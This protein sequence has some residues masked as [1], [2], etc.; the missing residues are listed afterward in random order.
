MQLL[1]ILK[2]ELLYGGLSKEEFQQVKEPVREQNQKLLV[3]WSIATGLFWAASLFLY[4]EPQFAQCLIVMRIS[5]ATS[6]FTLICALFL[7]ERIP[8][9]LDLCMLLLALGV[10]GNGIAL[11]LLQPSERVAAMIA[12]ALIIPVF[13]IDRTLTFVVLEAA[14]IVSYA[15]LGM[16]VLTPDVYSWGVKTMAIFSVAGI[17]SGHIINKVRYERYLYADSAEKLADLQRNY[18]EELEREVEAKTDRIVALHDKLIIGMAKMVESR[19]N[20]TGGHIQRTSEAVRI[21]TDVMREDASLRL[22]DDFYDAVVKA[23]PMHDLGKISVD[24]A[25]LRKPGRFT[26]EEYEEMK[27]HAPEGARILH[28][29]L[30]DTDDEGFRSIAENV[31]HYH[32]ERVDGSGYPSGLKGDEIP[33]EAR[34]MAIAD[35][36]DALVSKRVYKE[37]YSFEKANQII[38]EGMGSQFDPGLEKYYMAARPR[39]EAYYSQN[40]A[41]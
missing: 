41:G 4:N 23:A 37:S 5:L 24:D 30:A 13:F 22:A 3:A 10:L 29:V 20:S 18:N 7:V 39:L 1:M 15:V 28:G 2:R 8:W 38:L 40:E 35:V 31:A 9:L 27:M 14:S 12:F 26:P 36:Y 16:G 19:D 33:L 32:H 17:M 25:I 21:L 34:I 11:S 6:V